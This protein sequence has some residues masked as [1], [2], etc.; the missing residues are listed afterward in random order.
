MVLL[1]D[2]KV[3]GDIAHNYIIFATKCRER[4]F[5]VILILKNEHVYEVAGHVYIYERENNGCLTSSNIMKTCQ[6]SYYL[7]LAGVT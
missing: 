6:T 1:S 5:S 4:N 3:E 7:H 2:R